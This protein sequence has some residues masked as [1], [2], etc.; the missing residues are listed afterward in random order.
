MRNTIVSLA[1]GTLLAAG[2]SSSAR[3]QDNP[4][5]PPDQAQ[6][7]GG[8]RGGM[9]MDPNRQLERMTR[10][11]SLTADQQSQIKPMLVDR[12]QKMEAIYQDQSLSQEDRRSKMMSIRQESRGKIE[13]VLNGDQKQKFEAMEQRGPGRGG[14]G[15][16]PGGPPP[17]GGAPPQPQN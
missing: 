6:P 5:P 8:G 14:P 13:A 7:G 11:L 4:P 9:R 15:G 17:D 2:A 10:E 16:G 12:Q 3:A 1:L